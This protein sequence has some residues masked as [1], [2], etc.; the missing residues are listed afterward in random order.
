MICFKD[1]TFCTDSIYTCINTKCK[2]YLSEDV[3]QAGTS[4]WGHSDFPLALST[5]K[6]Y[7]NDYVQSMAQNPPIRK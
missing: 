5:F 3:I 2:R 7:C 6:E 1:M 4:W